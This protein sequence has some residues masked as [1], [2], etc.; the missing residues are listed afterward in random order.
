VQRFVDGF[1]RGARSRPSLL[2]AQTYDAARL[3]G[4]VLEGN[5]GKRPASRA[6]V[7]ASLDAVEGFAGVT[8]SISFDAEGDSVTPLHFFR[9]EREKVDTFEV[10][11]H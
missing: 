5:G 8:G 11:E 4:T 7:R 10:K 9:I 3:L 2:E 1:N 6:E